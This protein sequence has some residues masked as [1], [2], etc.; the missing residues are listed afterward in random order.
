MKR[1][2][3]IIGGGP[4]GL[5][6]AVAAYDNGV[7]DVLIVEREERLGGILLQ[8]IHNGFGLTRFKE[9]LTGPEYADRFFKEVLKRSIEYMT[10]ATVLNVTKDKEVT[11]VNPK[12][13]VLKIQ[14]KAIILAMRKE[15]RSVKY[16]RQQTRGYF[17][18][19]YHSEIYKRKR[20]FR[21]KKRGYFGV[22]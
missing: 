3:V 13:G 19:G 16:P 8:C 11:I 22:G 4:A 14:A 2:L 9:S 21:R 1:D 18:G 20:L 12:T 10:N 6:A 5:A 15:S 7:K 17:F